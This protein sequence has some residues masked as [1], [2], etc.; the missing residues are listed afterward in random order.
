MKR[1]RSPDEKLVN[2][3]D[4]VLKQIFGEN[5]TLIIYKY[6]EEKC[7]L[8]RGEIPSKPE[9]F[10][11]GLEMYLNSGAS[12]VARMILNASSELKLKKVEDKNF[13]EHLRE[14]KRVPYK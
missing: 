11:E 9:V 3:V 1:K 10:A 7:S 5:A 4:K 13:F 14:L 8:K 6:L 2:I 12:V